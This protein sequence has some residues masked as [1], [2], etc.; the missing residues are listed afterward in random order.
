LPNSELAGALIPAL[1]RSELL[2]R[3]YALDLSRGT[4]GDDEIDALIDNAPRFRHL[5]SLDLSESFL[6][7]HAAARIRK[8][9]DNVIVDGQHDPIDPGER[10]VSTGE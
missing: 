9:L 10:F 5:A 3:L 1:A 2:P 4:L 8:V 6:S 7:E